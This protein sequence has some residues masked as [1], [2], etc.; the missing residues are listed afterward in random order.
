[1][2]HDARLERFEDVIIAP[3]LVVG[4]DVGHGLNVELK[5]KNEETKMLHSNQ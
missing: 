2:Q 4:H 1:V 3:G 5:M